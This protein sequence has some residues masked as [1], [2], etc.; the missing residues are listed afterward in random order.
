MKK[1]ALIYKANECSI[2]ASNRDELHLYHVEFHIY[3][4]KHGYKLNGLV[5]DWCG[6]WM[7][8]KFVTPFL[9]EKESCLKINTVLD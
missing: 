4:C 6:W 8:G 3:I 9:P 7:D 2:K 1:E 5:N